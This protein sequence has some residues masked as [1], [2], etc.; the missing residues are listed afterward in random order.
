MIDGY[1]TRRK[2][3]LLGVLL[4]VGTTLSACIHTTFVEGVSINPVTTGDT[5]GGGNDDASGGGQF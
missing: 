1:F 5:D 2:L 4:A 3:L